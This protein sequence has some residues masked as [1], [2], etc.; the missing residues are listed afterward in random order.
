VSPYGITKLSTEKYLHYYKEVHDLQFVALRYAN[1]Y[2]PRQ[3]AH[4]D[5]GVVAIFTNMMLRG[6]QPTINGSGRQTRDYVFV[7]DVVR[8]NLKAIEYDSSGIFNVG[9]SKETSVNEL[10]EY[11]RRAT[12]VDVTPEYGLTKPGEQERSVLSFQKAN[13]ELSWVPTTDVEEGVRETVRWFESRVN[14]V[15]S[16]SAE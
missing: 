10:F 5:A 6:K 12:G 16:A 9:T 8:A 11:I 4:G 2:G 14:E 3:N 15:S 7:E 1:V 13:D